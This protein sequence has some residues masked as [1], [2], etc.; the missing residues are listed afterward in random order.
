MAY[1]ILLFMLVL[2]EPISFLVDGVVCQVY[3]K[4]VQIASH[5]TMV[6]LSC[7]PGQAL[8]VHEASLRI[9]SSDQDVYSEI[10]FETIDEVWFM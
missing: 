8:F 6:L 3:A 9:D 7:K 1:V 10:K 4:V 2:D 5:W